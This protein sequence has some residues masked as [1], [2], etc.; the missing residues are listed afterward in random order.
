MPIINDVKNFLNKVHIEMC[1][2]YP[3]K[4]LMLK[5]DSCE[6]SVPSQWAEFRLPR[7]VLATGFQL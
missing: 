5:I 7:R 6:S 1:I 2:G 3:K 4:C